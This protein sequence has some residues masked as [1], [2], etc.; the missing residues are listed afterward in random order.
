MCSFLVWAERLSIDIHVVVC[1]PK[2]FWADATMMLS[3]LAAGLT[4]TV[5]VTSLIGVAIV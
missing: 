3:A 1:F 5:E 4:P 2:F